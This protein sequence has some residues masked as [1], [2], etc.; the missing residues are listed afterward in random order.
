MFKSVKLHSASQSYLY[1]LWLRLSSPPPHARIVL[2]VAV[3]LDPG[4][5]CWDPDANWRQPWQS[6]PEPDSH[7]AVQC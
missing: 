7:V 3:H 5:K 1:A 2:G 4:Y 6:I